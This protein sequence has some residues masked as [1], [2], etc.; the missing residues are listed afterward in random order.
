MFKNA[1]IKGTF[2]LTVTGFLIR[3]IG[4][5]F[6]MFLSHTFGEEQV[7]LYQLIFPI[8][9]LCFS[10]SSAGIETALSRSVA[11]KMS[12]GKKQEADSLLYQGILISVS[13]SLILALL[14][15]KSATF[16]SIYILGDLR[17]EELLGTLA[18]TLP[19]SALHS[20]I[21]GYYIGQRQTKVPALSQLI[22][23]LVRVGAVYITYRLFTANGRPATIWIAV[24]GLVIGEGLSAVSCVRYFCI[25]PHTRVSL[26][27]IYKTRHLCKGLVTMALPLTSNRILMNLLQSV[28]TISIPLFLQR[29]GYTNSGAL[30]T[31]G[32]L[33]GMALP[34]ILFPTAVTNSVSTMLLPTVAEIQAEDNLDRLKQL[35]RKVIFFGFGLGSVCGIT[36]LLSGSLIGTFLF[37]S[38]LAGDFLRTLAWICPFLYMNSTLISILNGL[39]KAN[40]SFFIN[41]SGLTVRIAGVWFGI[42]YFG[43]NGYLIGLLISQLCISTFCIA[44]LKLYIASRH[45]EI[46]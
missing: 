38:A 8:Y 46:K 2:V 18:F 43:M 11:Q 19:F 15:R 41:V 13:L 28:E 10:L 7:G 31:Y 20:C 35:I 27:Q 6:R 9:A 26:S 32:V 37:N 34:C 16:L 29:Y 3:F 12:R 44:N 23:Q 30:S 42:P 39:G 21:C 5:F 36:F 1:I 25:R 4:F 45:P 17:C 40:I 14:L 33:T 24:F 22:E